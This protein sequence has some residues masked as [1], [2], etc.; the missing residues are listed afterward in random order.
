MDDPL[1]VRVHQRLEHALGDA[2]RLGHAQGSLVGDEQ[3]D[4]RAFH[5]LHDQDGVRFIV[6]EFVKAGDVAMAKL[7]E[8]LRLFDEAL[9]GRDFPRQ[10]L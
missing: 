7:G 6:D 4:R 9:A 8:D 3:I 5:V 10:L 1:P 2:H